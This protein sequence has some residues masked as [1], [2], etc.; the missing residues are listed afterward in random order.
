MKYYYFHRIFDI[1]KEPVGRG[2]FASLE[3]ARILFPR[4]KDLS[5]LE[6]NKLFKVRE[7]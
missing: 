1:S 4:Q 2:R 5:I 3:E 6:F 7:E